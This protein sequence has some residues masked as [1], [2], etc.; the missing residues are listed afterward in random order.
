MPTE[1]T[2]VAP[3][4]QQAAEPPKNLVLA[5]VDLTRNFA[6]IPIQNLPSA[7]KTANLG[8][9]DG[10]GI[11]ILFGAA[12]ENV[13]P[14]SGNVTDVGVG[15]TVPSLEVD[16]SALP[17]L[18]GAV[19]NFSAPA[20]AP[21]SPGLMGPDGSPMQDYLKTRM[22]APAEQLA[23]D[24]R[25]FEG[26]DADGMKHVANGINR[27]LEK[28]R[29]GDVEHA[30]RLSG[31]M[32]TFDPNTGFRVLEDDQSSLSL[33]ML[34]RG[35]GDVGNNLSEEARRNVCAERARNH[36]AHLAGLR[37]GAPETQK[38]DS[39]EYL[40]DNLPLQDRR[41]WVSGDFDRVKL[42]SDTSNPYV[43]LAVNG[44]IPGR[45]EDVLGLAKAFGDGELTSPLVMFRTD[46]PSSQA[47][48]IHEGAHVETNILWGKPSSDMTI[49]E[50]TTDEVIARIAEGE[51][52]P[53]RLFQVINTY[54]ANFA[55]IRAEHIQKMSSS[56][57]L[58]DPRRRILGAYKMDLQQYADPQNSQRI[59]TGTVD[60][61][62]DISDRLNYGVPPEEVIRN[63]RKA[64]TLEQYA[65][66]MKLG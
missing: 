24:L 33:D 30:L 48:R 8:V 42:A 28:G 62:L 45:P 35:L 43:E 38:A 56:E 32:L 5:P 6:D 22:P 47:T 63:L 31:N 58:S 57:H 10:G 66:D 64:H 52:D 1:K 23:E 26:Y 21:N 17:P 65:Q 40:L 36:K 13:S 19:D 54:R 29:L 37:E 49:E 59:A 41:K 9:V 53:N 46:N 50:L 51:K 7:P 14:S 44:P 61:L 12:V 15:V 39:M 11:R 34:Y 60:A 25:V 2:L 18:H 3:G 27:L 20:P 4:V 55:E 16:G